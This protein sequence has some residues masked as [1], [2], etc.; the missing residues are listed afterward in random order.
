MSS[1]HCSILLLVFVGLSSE[2]PELSFG[3]R[4]DDGLARGDIIRE[5]LRI[6]GRIDK[7]NRKPK[8]K[9]PL[10]FVWVRGGRARRSGPVAKRGAGRSGGGFAHWEVR[11]DGGL[12]SA[13]G[14]WCTKSPRNMVASVQSRRRREGQCAKSRPNVVASVQSRGVR[15]R[16]IPTWVWTAL[17][18]PHHGA[19]REFQPSF[20][21]SRPTHCA[22]ASHALN[23]LFS[24]CD[25]SPIGANLFRTVWRGPASR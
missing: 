20:R 19:G 13:G 12:Y 14:N 8:M 6:G 24:C 22:E 18:S 25:N 10:H 3:S 5:C 11:S 4:D 21:G 23:Y 7:R 15:T 9:G 16:G 2:L 1:T 17:A